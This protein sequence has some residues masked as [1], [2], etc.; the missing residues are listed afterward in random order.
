M[1]FTIEKKAGEKEIK[2]ETFLAI[3]NLDEIFDMNSPEKLV[4]IH[5]M[6]YDVPCEKQGSYGI[7]TVSNFS[8]PLT[9]LK[10]NEEENAFVAFGDHGVVL[11]FL[12]STL[13]NLR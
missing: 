10:L 7:Q 5:R 1:M 11:G 13:E 4:K 12:P 3:V 2:F 8:Y 9:N 6:Q